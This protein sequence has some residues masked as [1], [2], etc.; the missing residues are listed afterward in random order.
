MLPGSLGVA[1]EDEKRSGGT[2]AIE[3]ATEKQRPLPN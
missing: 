3:K 1:H 2:Q